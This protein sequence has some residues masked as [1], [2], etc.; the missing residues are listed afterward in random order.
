MNN[1]ITTLF[2]CQ[3]HTEV[4]GERW[5]VTMKKLVLEKKVFFEQKL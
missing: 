5:V 3:R 1:E 2:S 4:A